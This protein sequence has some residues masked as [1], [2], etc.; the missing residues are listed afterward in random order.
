MSQS[1]TST[2]LGGYFGIIFHAK[3]FGAL[4]EQPSQRRLVSGALRFAVLI[5]G[6]WVIDLLKLI[7][8][9]DEFL[10]HRVVHKTL[11]NFLLAFYMF[12]LCDP[13]CSYLGL[14][15]KAS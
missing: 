6:F 1:Y 5:A 13:I 2:I 3:F 11:P 8:T 14:N 4:K 9:T 7:K 12:A 15:R 10:Q